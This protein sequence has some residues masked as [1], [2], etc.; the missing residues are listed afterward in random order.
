MEDV[1]FLADRALILDEGSIVAQGT[2]RQLF[3]DPA[4]LAAHGLEVPQVTALMHGL[5]SRGLSVPSDVLTV[6]EALAVLEGQPDA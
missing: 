2:P 4:R 5:R 3:R 6:Q 1:A